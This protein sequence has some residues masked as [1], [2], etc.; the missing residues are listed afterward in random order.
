MYYLSHHIV[1][2]D[3]MHYNRISEPGFRHVDFSACVRIGTP[4]S[5]TIEKTDTAKV[6]V[7]FLDFTNVIGIVRNWCVNRESS[8]RI[9]DKELLHEALYFRYV[10]MSFL[11]ALAV[12]VPRMID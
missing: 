12:A 3:I 9:L 6:P 2:A 4:K 10:E 11:C 5:T 8:N 7:I 1:I